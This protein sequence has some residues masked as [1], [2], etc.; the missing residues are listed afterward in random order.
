MAGDAGTAFSPKR[1]SGAAAGTVI[2]CARPRDEE[3]RRDQGRP[4]V[5]EPRPAT[6][7][8]TDYFSGTLDTTDATLIQ[9]NLFTRSVSTTATPAD[10]HH[11]A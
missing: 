4:P 1:A 11:D 9:D 5:R 3:D 7:L 10:R 6:M 8:G 2:P